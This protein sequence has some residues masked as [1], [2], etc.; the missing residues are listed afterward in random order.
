MLCVHK[1]I[2]AIGY[3]KNEEQ[4]NIYSPSTNNQQDATSAN[5]KYHE[6]PSRSVPR[7]VDDATAT[8]P[9]RFQNFDLFQLNIALREIFLV[10]ILQ[11]RLVY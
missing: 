9:E 6:L 3:R 1:H 10:L 8:L 11:T 2:C 5:L 4:M 7:F